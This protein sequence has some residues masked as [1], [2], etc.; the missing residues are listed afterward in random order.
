MMIYFTVYQRFRHHK[1]FIYILVVNLIL[2][3]CHAQQNDNQKDVTKQHIN[4]KVSYIKTDTVKNVKVLI[5][6]RVNRKNVPVD[7]VSTTLYLNE[8]ST[9]GLIDTLITNDLGIA[10]FRVPGK[11][12]NASNEGQEKK[13]KVRLNDNRYDDTAEE[14]TIKDAFLD[15]S[16]IEKD[17]V[18]K[19]SARF[20]AM[21]DYKNK[22]PIPETS[23]K[24]YEKTTFS[25][26]PIGDEL[27]TDANGE[28]TIDLPLDL[29]SDYKKTMSVV[30]RVED[31]DYYGTLEANLIIPWNVLS[32]TSD[33][34]ETHTLW[35]SARNAPVPL[36]AIS[37][38]IIL[39]VWSLI[40]YLLFKL[41]QIWKLSKTFKKDNQG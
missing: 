19:L 34:I 27:L 24:F 4:L 9:S 41:F 16:Y 15:I 11:A 13:F 21:S 30:A 23:I 6:K 17:S 20:Y 36:L 2:F 32:V 18:K 37:I 39:A 28:A 35:S 12:K 31:N 29:E 1:I 26:L 3:T 38:S 7:G 40:F 22:V 14:L 25:L 5:T 33:K 10:L 8:I